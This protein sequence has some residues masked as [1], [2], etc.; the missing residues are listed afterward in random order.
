MTNQRT[1]RL[2]FYIFIGVVV[3]SFAS[4]Q[5]QSVFSPKPTP[6]FVNEPIYIGLTP[7]KIVRIEMELVGTGRK[8]VMQRLAAG[9]Q[10]T[11]GKGQPFRVNS[12]QINASLQ[13]LATLRYNRIVEGEDLKAFGLDGGGLFIVRFTADK[14]FGLHVGD[15]NSARDAVFVQLEGQSRVL[16]VPAAPLQTLLI[17]LSDQS[18]AQAQGTP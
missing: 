7:S 6:D 5:W 8:V 10:V 15:L 9:W 3:L 1:T 14:T 13:V 4:T 17:P 11:D 18:M 12:D 2:L 16:Q